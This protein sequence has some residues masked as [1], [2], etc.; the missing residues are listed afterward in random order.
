MDRLL[1]HRQKKAC[2]IECGGAFVNYGATVNGE[3]EALG[4]I[5]NKAENKEK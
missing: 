1:P 2:D 5:Y 3:I 4:G